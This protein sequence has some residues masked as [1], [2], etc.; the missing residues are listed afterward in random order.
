[1]LGNVSEASDVSGVVGKDPVYS[2]VGLVKKGI[3]LEFE[4]GEGGPDDRLG[5]ELNGAVGALYENGKDDGAVPV[6]KIG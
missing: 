5:Y 3:E 4:L 1:M 2:P 6:G